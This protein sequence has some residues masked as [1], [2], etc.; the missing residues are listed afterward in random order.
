MTGTR[1]AETLRKPVRTREAESV[2]AGVPPDTLASLKRGSN[3]PAVAQQLAGQPGE[4]AHQRSHGDS[5]A[6]EA[7]AAAVLAKE[8]A[9]AETFTRHRVQPVILGLAGGE[10]VPG[11]VG[12]NDD[13]GRESLAVP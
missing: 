11:Q 3:V 9:S 13:G 6:S 8:R 7:D 10:D 2:P 5:P 1:Q 12:L 4:N